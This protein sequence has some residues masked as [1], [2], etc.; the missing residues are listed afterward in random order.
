[1]AL[2]GSPSLQTAQGQNASTHHFRGI[3][4][5]HTQKISMSQ[6]SAAPN[7]E[8]ERWTVGALAKRRLGPCSDLSTPTTQ[9]GA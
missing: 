8:V 6:G 5:K 9:V 7:G 1:M 3:L 2:N 4:H